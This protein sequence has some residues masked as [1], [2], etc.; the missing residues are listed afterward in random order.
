MSTLRCCFSYDNP[1]EDLT[2]AL[3][4]EEKTAHLKKSWKEEGKVERLDG[5]DSSVNDMQFGFIVFSGM[6]YFMALAM[7]VLSVKFTINKQFAGD[8]DEVNRKSAFVDTT[9]SFLYAASSLF[10]AK[11]C[12]A[13]SDYLGRRPV[14]ILSCFGNICSRLLYLQAKTPAEYFVGAVVSGIFDSYYFT[15]LAM[16]SD[17]YPDRSV[18]TKCIGIY[19][20]LLGGTALTIGLPLG[21]ALAFTVGI[22][23]P[24]KVSIGMN[25]V[26]IVM[27]L[28][29]RVDDL[30]GVVTDETKIMYIF[31]R[32]GLPRQLWPFLV[33]N[34]CISSNTWVVFNEAEN[35]LDWITHSCVQIAGTV[36]NI[37]FIP[38]CLTVLH[39]TALGAALSILSLGILTP[40]A[41]GM[42]CNSPLYG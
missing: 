15:S 8:V 6:I 11:Y 24:L 27:N 10:S 23:V 26:C 19:N 12:A 21:I 13:L 14:N 22:M 29:M 40:L 7:S 38:Y 31:G 17:I 2:V 3:E 34:F 1:V 20:G 39:F 25:V 33:D 35:I 18:R 9:V 16:I 37:L 41:A 28:L 4:D 42:F 5:N 32:R 30:K 36:V